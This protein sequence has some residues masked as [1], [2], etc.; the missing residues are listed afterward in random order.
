MNTRSA[1]YIFVTGGV[2][3]SIGKGV[4]ASSI[5]AMLEARG[6]TVT[7][8]K[9]DPYINVDPGTMNP[10]QHGEV[11]VTDDGTETDLDLGHY[12]RFTSATMSRMSNATTG[13]IYGSVIERERRGDYLGGTV[14]VIPHITDEIKT[15]VRNGSQGVDICITEVGGTVGDIESLPFLEAL[16]QLKLELGAVNALNVH[17]TLVPYIAAAGE[18]KTKPTQHSVQKLREIGIQPEI[19][20]ARCDR[21]LVP[22]L[23]RKISLFC[24]VRPEAVINGVDASSIYEVPISFHRQGLDALIVEHLNIWTRDPVLDRWEQICRALKETTKRVTVAIVGKYVDHTD[25]Y[26]S[27]HEALLHGGIAHHTKVDLRYID[28]ESIEEQGAKA[29]LDGSDAILVPGGFGDRGTEGKIEAICYAREH[30]VPFFGICL[31]LQLAV[32]EYCRNV[33]NVPEANSVEFKPDGLH[34]VIH[35][36]AHQHKVVRKG[37]SMRLGSYD[38]VLDPSSKAAKIYG[39][40]LVSERH[41]H[42]YEVN[43]AYRSMME[44]RGV[45]FSGLSPDKELVEMV[46]L[47]SHPWFIGCQF[48]PEFKSRPYRPHPLFRS[49]IEAA[50]TFSES[51]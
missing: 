12:E 51:T 39:A 8:I 2:S 24:N 11:F 18:L 28:S 42:R 23:K 49:F 4:V 46:E 5:G 3:S 40:T 14:Q 29:L 32:V 41:R 17:V 13:R 34:S 26:K 36:M 15:F 21:E 45:C 22:E 25:A 20:V 38:C 10:F 16:R 6:L 19:I 9:L 31:G 33:C 48:H 43:N 44:E 37:G 47:D 7:H 35:L 30:G 27:L 50:I 1:K